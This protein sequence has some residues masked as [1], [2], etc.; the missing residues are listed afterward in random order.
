MGDSGRFGAESAPMRSHRGGIHTG[1]T[2]ARP[3][4][5][6]GSTEER[7]ERRARREERGEKEEE[8]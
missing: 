8:I 3:A 6:P 5:T 7:E 4:I 2:I 1:Q